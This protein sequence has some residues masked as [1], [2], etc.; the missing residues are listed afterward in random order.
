MNPRLKVLPRLIV[1]SLLAARAPEPTPAEPATRVIQHALGETTLTG[2]PQ[3]AEVI[4]AVMVR[5]VFKVEADIVAD[6]RSGA[7]LCWPYALHAP[8]EI[9]E[10]V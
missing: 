7:P 10:R 6:P 4:T 5:S 3:R 9:I 2:T 8:A 1:L